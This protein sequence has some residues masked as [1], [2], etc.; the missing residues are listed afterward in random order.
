MFYACIF[1]HK[2]GEKT[3]Q[4]LNIRKQTILDP[5]VGV[6]S[7]YMMDICVGKQKINE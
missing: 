1:L 6:M 4:N 3:Q 5:R 2:C 7:M